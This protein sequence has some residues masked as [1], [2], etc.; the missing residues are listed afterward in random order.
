MGAS[1]E[2][3]QLKHVGAISENKQSK[4]VGAD[5]DI[6]IFKSVQVLTISI[7]AIKVRTC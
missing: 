7:E 1:I 4:H 2:N 6:I 3:K 5:S